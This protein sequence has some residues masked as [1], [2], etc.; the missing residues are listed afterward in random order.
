MEDH[1]PETHPQGNDNEH[2]DEALENAQPTNS[3]RKTQHSKPSASSSS[4]N[5][6]KPGGKSSS[7]TRQRAKAA[8]AAPLGANGY[9]EPE[10]VESQDS[11][12]IEAVFEAAGEYD[13]GSVTL[14][15]A[16]NA[17]NDHQLDAIDLLQFSFTMAHLEP[18]S[19]GTKFQGE[20][21][22]SHHPLVPKVLPFTDIPQFFRLLQSYFD[23][24]DAAWTSEYRTR[25]YL[26]DIDLDEATTPFTVVDPQTVQQLTEFLINNDIEKANKWLGEK[27]TYHID[28]HATTAGADEPFAFTNEQLDLA[29]EW[30]ESQEDVHLIVRVYNLGAEDTKLCIYVDPLELVLD[31]KLEIASS[32]GY[33]LEPKEG[34]GEDS[35]CEVGTMVYLLLYQ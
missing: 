11:L 20:L 5:A 4:K 9:R 13:I 18:I 16:E 25:L 23:V 10:S 34:E 27:I 21:F 29:R 14:V 35:L 17:E 2:N 31:G 30:S 15:A 8:A 26:P 3:A 28:V 22:V 33:Y 19:S 12:L 1:V 32:T 24:S 6:K 7:S